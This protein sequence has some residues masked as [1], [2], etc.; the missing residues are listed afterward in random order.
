MRQNI[1][2]ESI[3]GRIFSHKLEEKVGTN[4]QSPNYNKPY[5]SGTI[6]VATDEA[7]LNVITVHYTFVAPTTKAGGK[8]PSYNNLKS[9]IDNG[10][11][12]QNDG[13]DNAWK[14]KLTPSIAL[15]EFYAQGSDELTSITRNEG[16]FVTIIS[17]LGPESID[18]NKFTA[19]VLI[20]KVIHIDADPEKNIKED[21]TIVKAGVFNFRNDLLPVDFIARQPE[22]MQYFEGL[23]IP[24]YTKIWGKIVNRSEQTEVHTESAFGGDAVDIV[25]KKVREY[26]ITGAAATP[27][28][29][30]AEGVLTSEEVKE[31]LANR[32]V[33]LAEEKKREEEYRASK[34]NGAAA[35]TTAAKVPEGGFSF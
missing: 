26:V 20:N 21:Y 27:Y 15:N 19:D 30:G 13:I 17:D 16:G 31:A 5:I 9:I 11:T 18:R 4:K 8:N 34:N 10:K 2:Q 29:F 3:I 12:I 25:Q 33:R 6:D 7:S 35:A 23:E 14:V 28:E 22:A 24:T 1:N 32:E